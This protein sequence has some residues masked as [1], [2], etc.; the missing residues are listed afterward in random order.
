MVTGATT[1]PVSSTIPSEN[2]GLLAFGSS[3]SWDVSV[4]ESVSGAERSFAQIEGPSLW[5]YFEIPSPD[6]ILEIIHFLL[7]CGTKRG[8]MPSCSSRSS[9]ELHISDAEE[10]PVSL[11]MDDEYKDRCFIVVGRSDS[12]IV[13]FSLAGEDLKNLTEALRQ[14]EEDIHPSASSEEKT[15]DFVEHEFSGITNRMSSGSAGYVSLWSFADEDPRRA[16]RLLNFMCS[17]D[18]AKVRIRK[19]DAHW[20]RDKRVRSRWEIRSPHVPG[21][22]MR[23]LVD[24]VSLMKLLTEQG[25]DPATTVNPKRGQKDR[26]IENR[27]KGV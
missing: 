17:H 24:S 12:P 2:L 1:I 25:F 19:K 23:L 21:I 22:A 18:F 10:T 9:G 26:W 20:L 4:D 13:R 11:V 15:N 6:I 27:W 14:V 3:G 7:D 16:S 8:E 5:L